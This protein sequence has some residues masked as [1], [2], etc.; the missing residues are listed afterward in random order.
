MGLDDYLSIKE[1]IGDNYNK[2]LELKKELEEKGVPEHLATYKSLNLLTPPKLE[3]ITLI[4]QKKFHRTGITFF[5]DTEEDLK[6][7]TKYFTI[8]YSTM[9]AKDSVLLIELLKLL[10]K[11]NEK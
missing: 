1:R 2:F 6:L 4:T 3:K 7:A 5:F 9:Q 11:Y 8:S 10:E